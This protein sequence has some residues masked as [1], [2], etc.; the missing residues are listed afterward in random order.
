MLESGLRKGFDL[1]RVYTLH[2]L[3]AFVDTGILGGAL[4][5][6]PHRGVS[7]GWTSGGG[8]K[9]EFNAL[10][11]LPLQDAVATLLSPSSLMY[12]SCRV[13]SSA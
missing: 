1:S 8:N 5:G 3:C 9:S 10:P 7:C 12:N 6:V 13:Y 4:V 2:S 11:R